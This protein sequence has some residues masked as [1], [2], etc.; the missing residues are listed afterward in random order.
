MARLVIGLT[1]EDAPHLSAQAKADL[2]GSYQE[3]ELDARTR[4]IPSL[5]SGAVYP[6]AESA[7]RFNDEDIRPL[8]K[9]WRF[10]FALDTA[11]SGTTAAVWGALDPE[12]QVLYI[13]SVY[14]VRGQSTANHAE[15]LKSRGKWI[16]GVGDAS[17]VVDEDR[18]QFLTLYRQHGLDLMLADK[19]V[20][21]GIQEVY[22]RFAAAKLKVAKSC[23]AWFER[24]SSSR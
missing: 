7:I 24:W 11:L 6:F 13:Y 20:E 2:M 16:P 23:A 15:A 3:Y 9:H 12:T 4:G 21:V 14:K 18:K 8:P 19:S 5:G 17:G 10:G 22:N 1:W